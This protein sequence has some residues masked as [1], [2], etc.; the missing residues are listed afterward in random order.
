MQ[1]QKRYTQNHFF[2]Q[3]INLLRT[4]KKK[5]KQQ[6]LKSKNGDKIALTCC[7]LNCWCWS[8]NI[9][10]FCCIWFYNACTNM[11]LNIW[12]NCNIF[13]TQ[14]TNKK[15]FIRKIEMKLIRNDLLAKSTHVHYRAA[16]L[17]FVVEPELQTA[18]HPLFVSSSLITS[19]LKL[20]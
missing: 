3:S 16:L 6:N 19:V 5:Q 9:W 18:L 12:S 7:I 17:I 4:Q 1:T 15:L 20:S 2:F 13:S 10:I 14:N 8:T 11:I